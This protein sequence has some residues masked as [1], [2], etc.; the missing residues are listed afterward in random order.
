MDV[1]TARSGSGFISDTH[2]LGVHK[3]L[4]WNK[5]KADRRSL[6][7]DGHSEGQLHKK[8]ENNGKNHSF[9]AFIA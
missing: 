2:L 8:S 3:I 9:A 1:V 5:A 6:F 4:T 7:F